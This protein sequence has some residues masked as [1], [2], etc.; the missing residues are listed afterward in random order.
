MFCGNGDAWHPGDHE[1]AVLR[2]GVESYEPEI[3]RGPGLSP[4]SDLQIQRATGGD[5]HYLDDIAVGIAAVGRA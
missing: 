5:L 4:D 2:N 3:A 1:C